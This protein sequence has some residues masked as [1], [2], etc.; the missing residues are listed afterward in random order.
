MRAHGAPTIGRRLSRRGAW[1]LLLLALAVQAPFFDRGLSLL[2]EGTVAATA[3][4]LAR[5]EALYRDR[6]TVIAPLSYELLAAG[7][8]TFGSH[9]AV[10]RALQ[11]A[12]FAACV[13]LS[14]A[15]L[16]RTAGAGWA[17]AGGILLL[18]LKPLGF[19]SWT[20]ANYS[21]F[22]L[23]ALLLA[24][25]ALVRWLDQ[26]RTADLLLT[27]LASGL[28]FVAKQNLAAVAAAAVGASVL[29]AWWASP[30]RR[31]RSLFASAGLLLGAS[32]LPV[33]AAA[34][35]YARLGALRPAFEQLVTS[36]P[37]FAAAWSLPFPSPA[38]WSESDPDFGLQLFAFLPQPVIEVALVGGLGPWTP[39]VLRT[40]EWAVKLCYVLPL[41]ASAL[42]A[43]R[44]WAE[45]SRRAERSAGL[46]CALFAAG[47]YASLWYRPDW[48]HL[49]NVWPLLHV[50]LVAAVAAE[51]GWLRAA[52]GGVFGLVWL[53]LAA[54]A[55]VSLAALEWELLETPRGRLRVPAAVAPSAR[56]VLAWESAR[57]ASERVAFLPA[58]PGLHFLSGRP[59]PL[60][61]DALLPA[62]FG[63]SDE[64]RMLH[65]LAAVEHVVFDDKP[66]P[67][68]RGDIIDV[69][70]RLARRIA[71]EFRFVEVVAPGFFA[72]ARALPARAEP[73]LVTDLAAE[74]PADGAS[75]E[76]WLFHRVLAWPL[77][78]GGE[79]RCLERAWRVASGDRIVATP[80]S[81]PSLWQ[82][83][84]RPEAERIGFELTVLDAE[85]TASFTRSVRSPGAPEAWTVPVEA[86]PGSEAV[87]R[88][89]AWRDAAPEP[90]AGGALRAGW[91]EPRVERGGAGD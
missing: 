49:M 71:T 42:L 11:C 14:F 50:A 79:R 64:E 91:A 43:A 82:R 1:L 52:L 63:P 45:P 66:L 81:H 72:F 17:L 61:V 48:A 88:L 41:A 67:G 86:S 55:C 29:A 40:S 37:G 56:A 65:Q 46:A 51:R 90:A 70:P 62:V 7:Y 89:C 26:R 87:L 2:D 60:A 39:L 57:P 68:V 3:D 34:L 59:L 4:A 44:W 5:G 78:R 22:G 47:A 18:A 24:L 73:G 84:S 32:L 33:G 20:I 76:H 15:V 74:A 83:A 28:V 12:V 36:M 31:L 21:P 9:V 10:G 27:G 13:L 69:A 58:V 38:P 16:R 54:V 85:R 6:V 30:P 80:I 75:L 77:E 19:F 23:L 25:A 53:A 35:R 8:R